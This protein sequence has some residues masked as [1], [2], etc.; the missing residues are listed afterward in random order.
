MAAKELKSPAILFDQ[1]HKSELFSYSIADNYQ[2][3]PDSAL[4]YTA[5]VPINGK[6]VNALPEGLL[7]SQKDYENSKLMREV[8]DMLAKF[9]DENRE[10]ELQSKQTK[11]LLNEL[12]TLTNAIKAS[13]QII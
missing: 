2:N 10:G 9:N 4:F 3:V 8:K 5:F 13:E 12:M 7:P 11:K 1:V 6:L